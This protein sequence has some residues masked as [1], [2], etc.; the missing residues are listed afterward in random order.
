MNKTLVMIL[1]CTGALALCQRQA[2]ATAFSNP[3]FESGDFAGWVTQDLT[4][5]FVS[6]QV[7]VPGLPQGLAS[8]LPHPPM[9]RLPPCTVLTAM[10]QREAP[11]PSVLPRMS[12]YPATARFCSITE[13]AGTYSILLRV[14]NRGC[15]T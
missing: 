3:S 6:L 10:G 12:R 13:P 9:V 7:G 4:D 1:V 11:T 8:L 14:R 2:W 5:P 15:S